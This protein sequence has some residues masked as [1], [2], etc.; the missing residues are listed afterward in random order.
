MTHLTTH[1]DGAPFRV[2]VAGGGIAAL[3]TA[4]VL[5]ATARDSVAVTVVAPDTHFRWRALDVG[6]PFGLGHPVQ[7]ELEGL[8]NEFGARFRRGAVHAVRRE[9]RDVVLQSGEE[10]EY[11][12]LVLAVGAEAC[13]AFE[14]GVSFDRTVDAEAF[15]E[16]LRDVGDHIA[17][18]VLV[19][20]PPGVTW[21]LPAYELA[22]M[23]AATRPGATI[24]LVTEERTPLSLFGPTASVVVAQAL[25]AAGV[26]VITDAVADVVS[27]T[28]ARVGSRWITADRIVALPELLGP[29]IGGVPCDERGFTLIGD[30]H[31]VPGSDGRVFA[32]GDGAATP[33]KQGGLAAQQAAV[34]VAGIAKL[35]GAGAPAPPPSARLLRGILRTTARPIYLYVDLDAP[36]TTSAASTRALWWPPSKVAAPRLAARIAELDTRRL[37]AAG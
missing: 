29:R 32:I 21:P 34:A 7:Y 11:D 30:D 5:Q 28:A 13:P 37:V 24:T 31:A 20:V 19:V 15:D 36:A 1:S 33:V 3:E 2:V 25:E 27:D 10:L 9:V 12:A 18:S 16:L 26:A 17:T 14:A 6:E 4:A 23:T 22:L 8:C 35:A